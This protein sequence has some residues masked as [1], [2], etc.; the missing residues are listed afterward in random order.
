M[1]VLDTEDRHYKVRSHGKGN[2]ECQEAMRPGLFPVNYPLNKRLNVANQQDDP[3]SPKER[4][5]WCNSALQI[6]PEVGIV[7]KFHVKH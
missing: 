4:G 3:N 2:K 7:P 5:R 6:S 1:E